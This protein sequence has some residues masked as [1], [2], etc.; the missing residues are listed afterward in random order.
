ML[1]YYNTWKLK[2]PTPN[3]FVR[4]MEKVS[5]MQLQWYLRYWIGTTKRIDYSIGLVADKVDGAI[6]E[7]QR[8]GELP[9]PIELE[10]T[11]KNGAKQHY[12]VPMN[13]TLANKP[14]EAGSDRID[15]AAWPWANPT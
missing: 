7:L 4:V 10:V 15:N 9:M 12:Y 13:E 5:G 14:K 8:I 1:R 6:V 3:D 11:L 2:H